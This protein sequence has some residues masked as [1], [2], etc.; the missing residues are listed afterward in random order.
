MLLRVELLSLGELGDR[1]TIVFIGGKD[2]SVFEKLLHILEFGLHFFIFGFPLVSFFLRLLYFC[3][4]GL[5]AC[6][7][8]R[9]RLGGTR[10]SFDF[11]HRELAAV[12]WRKLDRQQF[13]R[14]ANTAQKR[15]GKPVRR[16]QERVRADV[17][18]SRMKE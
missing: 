9:G 5:F 12:A 14:G 11:I 3:R 10:R 6:R 2:L 7:C 15:W 1:P 13:T 16:H 18:N 4:G 8:S 17:R